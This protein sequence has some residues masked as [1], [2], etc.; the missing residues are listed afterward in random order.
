[1]EWLILGVV[2]EN[3]VSFK[4]TVHQRLYQISE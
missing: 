4:Y 3:E 2:C 1:M